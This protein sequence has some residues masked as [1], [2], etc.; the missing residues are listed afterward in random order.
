MYV[1]PNMHSEEQHLMSEQDISKGLSKTIQLKTSD[2]IRYQ[3]YE[4]EAKT[5][6]AKIEDLKRQ[7]HGAKK[8]KKYALAEKKNAYEYV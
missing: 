1:S 3:E 6:S 2:E 5:L 8:K 4:D 7:M